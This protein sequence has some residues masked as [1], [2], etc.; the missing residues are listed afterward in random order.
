MSNSTISTTN[1]D[2]SSDQTDAKTPTNLN[3]LTERI[4]ANL[5]NNVVRSNRPREENNSGGGVVVTANQASPPLNA[6]GK[7]R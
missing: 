4:R 5:N 1:L 6:S 2:Q 3:K 7:K